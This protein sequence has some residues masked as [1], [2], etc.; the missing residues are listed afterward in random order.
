SALIG[1]FAAKELFVSQL[2]I[3]FSMTDS[4]QEAM[5]LQKVLQTQYTPLQAFCMMVFC[6]VSMPC[7]GTVA[8]VRRETNSWTLTLLQFLGLTLSAWLLCFLI[9]QIGSFLHIGT[10]LL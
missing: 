9:Y 3:L 1:A 4:S 6:L 7:I 5:P 2:G 10:N 8:V